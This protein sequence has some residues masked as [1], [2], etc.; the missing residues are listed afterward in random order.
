MPKFSDFQQLHQIF[1]MLRWGILK[2]PRVGDFGWSSGIL[3]LLYDSGA[4]ASEI[5]TLDLDY[6]DPRN[7]TIAVLGKGN[8]YRLINLCPKTASLITNYILNYRIDPIPV[9]GHRLFINQRKREL[10]RHGIKGC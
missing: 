8:R 4:R 3:N 6:F 7:E 1:G 10:T 2:W 9:Y 5:A